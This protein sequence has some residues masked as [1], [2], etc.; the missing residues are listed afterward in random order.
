MKRVQGLVSLGMP[1]F[2][3]AAIPLV[4]AGCLFTGGGRSSDVPVMDG[5]MHTT[6]GGET[7][8]AVASAYSV[9]V[10][11]LKRV[12]NLHGSNE[13]PEGTRLFIPGASE[14]RPVTVSDVQIREER[15]G[16]YHPVSRGETLIAIANAYG[17]T[18]RELQ[19]VNNIGNPDRLLAG[20]NIWIPGAKEVQDV[21]VPKVTIVTADPMPTV[22]E[23]PRVVVKVVPTPTPTPTPKAE[24]AEEVDFPRKV[25]TPMGNSVRFQW[26]LK[27]TFRILQ[28]FDRSNLNFGID[29]GAEIGTPVHAAADGRVE[30]VGGVGDDLGGQFGNYIILYHGERNGRGMRTIYAHN[31]QN[32]VQ[33]GQTVK[34]GE[35]IAT[36]GN[37]GRAASGDQGVLHFQIREAEESLDPMDEL[38]AFE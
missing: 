8:S 31:Q 2:A 12:N 26:P 19:R 34:R 32:M 20:D 27:D 9:S 4:L 5:V 33:M 22:A 18:V 13:L 35:Q 29:L 28:R 16:L 21:E 11:L 7:L 14:L 30:L 38:P 24:E 17:V 36:V 3:A 6:R 1:L 10:P 23:E 37:I 15:D 25:T